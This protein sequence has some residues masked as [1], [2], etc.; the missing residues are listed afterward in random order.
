[1]ATTTHGCRISGR[2]ADDL[3]VG[4]GGGHDRHFVGAG[5][6]QPPDVVERADSAPTVSGMKQASAVR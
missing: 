2:F 5:E 4:D 3:T 6:K 1:M